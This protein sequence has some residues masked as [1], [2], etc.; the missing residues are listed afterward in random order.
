MKHVSFPK[1]GLSFDKSF[2][3]F[4]VLS[5]LSQVNAVCDYCPE[6]IAVGCIVSVQGFCIHYSPILLVFGEVCVVL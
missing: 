6:E 4:V 5:F 3:P 2:K 1:L